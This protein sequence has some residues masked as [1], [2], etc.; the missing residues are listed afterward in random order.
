MERQMLYLLEWD[1]RVTEQDLFDHLEPFLAPIRFQLELQ[2]ER[3]DLNSQRQWHSQQSS[4][5]YD[6]VESIRQS[7]KQIVEQP[8]AIG[9]YDSP[10]S[11][12]EDDGGR[13]PRHAHNQ[14]TLSLPAP[15]HKRRPS[16]YRH[17]SRSISPPS[18][19][20]LP[21]LIRSGT[22]GTMHSHSSSRS[23]SLAPSSRSRSS[24]LAPTTRGTPLS[25]TYNDDIVVIDCNVSPDAH[26]YSAYG[27]AV[28]ATRP[29][30]KGHQI[31]FQGD[32]QQPSKKVKSDSSGFMARILNAGSARLGRTPIQVAAA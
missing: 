29:S 18:V 6:L 32:S 5:D 16:P 7:T 21:P 17:D 4:I 23:S 8:R 15:S 24:S 1:T 20:D 14:S 9:V 3:A 11:Y 26:Q 31:S 25:N 12:V 10:R 13:H 27:K 30:L 22:A 2:Y 28:A 19:R